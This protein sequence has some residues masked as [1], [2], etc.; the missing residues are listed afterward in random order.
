MKILHVLDHNIHLLIFFI[1]AILKEQHQQSSE[2]CHYTRPKHGNYE[3]ETELVVSVKVY[4][5]ATITGLIVKLA[6]LNQLAN[7]PPRF[8][9]SENS[10]KTVATGKSV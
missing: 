1:R 3:V 9:A 4:R 10:S 7:I 8:K 2:T 5:S 6:V